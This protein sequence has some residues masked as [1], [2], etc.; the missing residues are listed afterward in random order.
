[1]KV[2]NIITNAGLT[3][4]TVTGEIEITPGTE[5]QI[6]VLRPEITPKEAKEIA[7]LMCDFYDQ[8]KKMVY[9]KSFTRKYVKVRRMISYVLSNEF[10]ART[11]EIGKIL[12]LDHSTVIYNVKK[13]KGMLLFYRDI[14]RDISDIIKLIQRAKIIDKVD[15]SR[16]LVYRPV[17]L[18]DDYKTYTLAAMRKIRNKK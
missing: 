16:P 12:K 3:I 10:A 8:P 11:T 4:L 9:S 15:D 13:T 1:M 6:S 14:R 2:T 18:T 17:R 5:I 7:D